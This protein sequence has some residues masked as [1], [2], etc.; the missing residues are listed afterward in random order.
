MEARLAIAGIGLYLP[1]SKKRKPMVGKIGIP[2]AIL[3]ES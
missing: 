3:A 1:G 2:Y